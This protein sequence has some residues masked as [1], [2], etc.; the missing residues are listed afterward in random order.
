MI[1]PMAP[2]MLTALISASSLACDKPGATER[3]KEEQAG[4][5]VAQAQNEAN[6]QLQN[7]QAEANKN[8]ASARA[9][10]E[11][12][13]E[14]YRHGRIKDLNDFDK[15]VADLDA[16]AQ[17]AT[18]A[19]RARLAASLPGLHAQRAAFVRDMVTLDSATAE[20]WDQAK[21]N[22]DREWD[23]LDAALDKAR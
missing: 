2:L 1:R 6:Q 7:A 9:T 21:A 18:G 19:R 3:Q 11:N 14:D 22:L 17:T 20:T 16:E 12:S 10:F 4:Q 13:R 15:K 8:M 5:Q 23:A